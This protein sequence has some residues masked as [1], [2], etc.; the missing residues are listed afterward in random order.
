MTSLLWLVFGG[1][2]YWLLTRKPADFQV[3]VIH[4]EEVRTGE[5][6]DLAVEISHPEGKPLDLG[7]IDFE[8]TLLDGFRIVSVTPPS[9]SSTQVPG[10]LTYE[11]RP[12][13]ASSDYRF[14]LRLQ[15]TNPGYWTGDIDCCTVFE[16]FIT[17]TTGIEV[18]AP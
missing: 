15:A 11:C 17:S 14:T 7:S 4:P 6:F 5:E 8:K 18:V 3:K 13:K 10:Y 16:N 1:T 2:T 9:P 12:S